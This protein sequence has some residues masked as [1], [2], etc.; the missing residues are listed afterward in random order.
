MATPEEY[1]TVLTR[2]KKLFSVYYDKTKRIFIASER[3]T[4]TTNFDVFFDL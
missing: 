4:D 1:A 3:L 2:V